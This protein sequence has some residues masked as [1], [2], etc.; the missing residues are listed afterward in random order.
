MKLKVDDYENMINAGFTRCGTY[1]YIRNMT[2]SCC[3]PYSYRVDIDN[4]ILSDSQKKVMKR[5]HN[6]LNYGSIHKPNEEKEEKKESKKEKEKK[7]D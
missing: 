1:C 4:Y 5:F 7:D 3:E 6:Y 2:M